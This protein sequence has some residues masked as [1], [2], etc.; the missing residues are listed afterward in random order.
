MREHVRQVGIEEE[1]LLFRQ[2]RPELV[3]AGP[4][5]VAAAERATP[6]DA[7]FEKELKAAQSELATQPS[8]DLD[9]VADELAQRRGGRVGPPRERGAPAG[10]GGARPAAER[11][12]PP[13]PTPR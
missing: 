6:D 2:D 1:F 5:V 11:P 4:R 10:A 13:P 9:A 8:A 3:D 12:P 7:Q